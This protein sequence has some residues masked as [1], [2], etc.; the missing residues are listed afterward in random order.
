MLKYDIGSEIEALSAPIVAVRGLTKT[1]SG[2]STA[3]T[4]VSEVSFD[5]EP[6]VFAAITGPSGSGKSTLLHLLGGIEKPTSGEINVS[7]SAE[8][9]RL[10]TLTQA[11]QSESGVN[12][13]EETANLIRYQQAYQA[14]AKVMQTASTMFDVLLTLGH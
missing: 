14:A 9:A 6:G 8:V 7:G 1:F 12:V 5:L 10:D 13:D 2:G 3:L 4:A 11:Q